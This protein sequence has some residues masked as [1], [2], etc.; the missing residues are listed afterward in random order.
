MGSTLQMEVHSSF[1]TLEPYREGWDQ[2]LL[3]QASNI[4]LSFDWCRIWW[5]SFGKNLE[6]SVLLF[7]QNG[8]I[9]GILPLLVDPLRLGPFRIRIAR[10]LNSMYT[11]CVLHPPVSPEFAGE[12]FSSSL[13][14]LFGEK[15][16]DVLQFGYVADTFRPFD[17]LVASVESSKEGLKTWK[18][19]EVFC[20]AVYPLPATIEA[21]SQ[22]LSPK[23]RRDIFRRMR[24]LEREVGPIRI[25]DFTSWEAIQD[26]YAPFRNLHDKYWNLQGLGGHFVDLPHSE[27][28]NLELTRTLAER[29]EG[30]VDLQRISAGETAI[31]SQF[32]FRFGDCLHWRV[33]ARQF[34]EEWGRLA[35]GILSLFLLV[36]DSIQKGIKLIEAGPGHFPYKV[37]MGAQERPMRSAVAVR[38][39]KTSILKVLGLKML[40]LLLQGVYYKFWYRGVCKRLFKKRGPF[41]LYY[42]RCRL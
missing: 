12:I 20:H 24:A 29:G 25:E 7:L 19:E 1:D 33:T 15:R 10:L 23:R 6:L 22:S 34:G 9:V 27:D 41:S 30:G 16:C 35:V 42:L 21:Y 2:F 13:A 18:V 4:Y 26:E 8:R 36:E 5:K 37:T 39:S 40:Y 38:R 17:D 11:A 32:C 14:Y 31:G 28:F 3:G